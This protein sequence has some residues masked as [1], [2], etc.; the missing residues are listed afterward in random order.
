MIGVGGN[1][2]AILQIKKTAQNKIGESVET[3]ENYHQ[4]KGWLD[5]VNGGAS[6]DNY[7]AI[8]QE[9][10]HVFICDYFPVALQESECRLLIDNKPYE[11][12]L[13][14]N[15]MELNQHLEFYLKYT[16]D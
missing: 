5:F 2:S 13:I 12:T 6:T 3:Y 8:I 4:F 14:D 15:P 9:S 16:G 11:I 7:N 1:K 10:T